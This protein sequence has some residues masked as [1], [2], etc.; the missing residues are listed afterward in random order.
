MKK[1]T[2][3]EQYREFKT[4]FSYCGLFLLDLNDEDLLDILFEDFETCAISYL[5]TAMLNPLRASGYINDEIVSLCKLLRE[6]YFELAINSNKIW[7]AEE[8]RHSPDWLALFRLADQIHIQLE[9][10]TH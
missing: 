5:H 9:K 7:C 4:S 6:R 2:I 1:M 3:E 10:C 8:I